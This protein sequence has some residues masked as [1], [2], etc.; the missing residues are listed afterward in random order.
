MGIGLQVTNSLYVP[1]SL[2]LLY[3]TGL[4]IPQ[5]FNENGEH[6]FKHVV[7]VDTIIFFHLGFSEERTKLDVMIY[8]HGFWPHSIIV[9]VRFASIDHVLPSGFI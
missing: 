6:Y 7:Q 4:Q 8:I 1:N 5:C 3:L 9:R 2:K